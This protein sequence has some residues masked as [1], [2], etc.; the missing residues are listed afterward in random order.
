MKIKLT[1]CTNFTCLKYYPNNI[2]RGDIVEVSDEGATYLLGL[3]FIDRNTNT[4]KYFTLI[5]ETPPNVDVP[6]LPATPSVLSPNR[7]R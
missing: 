2:E 5:N 1:G 6:P 3:S 4:V 7:S